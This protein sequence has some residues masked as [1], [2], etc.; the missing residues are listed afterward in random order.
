VKAVAARDG[1]IQ[2]TRGV[3]AVEAFP[4]EA[5]IECTAQ[6]LRDHGDTL[7][8][9]HPVRGFVPLRQ[10]LAEQI[11]VSVDQ[12]LV[13]NGSIQILDSLTHALFEPGDTILV[14]RPTYDRTVTTFRRAGLHVKGVSLDGDGM[15]LDELKA[16]I[17][18]HAPKALYVIP[19]FQNPSG[20]TTSLAKREAILE[21][22][23]RHRFLIV[24]DT[25][26]RLLRYEGED[27]TGFRELRAER[28]VEL[29]SF[30]KLISPGLRVGWMVASKAIVDRV[31]QV[32]VDTYISPSMLSHGAV[33]EF[34]RRGWMPDN[35][36][37]LKALYGPR[38][39]ATL[40]ALSSSL[41][42]VA[43]SHPE[44][45]FFLALTLPEGVSGEQMCQLAPQEGLELTRGEG[46]Y[47][48]GDGS[49]FLRLPFC[50]LRED[51]IKEAVSRLARVLER[52]EA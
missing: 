3:P 8:Q 44:G 48:D 22:A 40:A 49:R 50:A 25:P 28:V 52:A 45:G 19:D 21:L 36:E 39:R 38:L 4:T 41:P 46:F 29:S 47:A 26:Y 51:E 34:L 16:A 1:I 7:L 13:G 6:A 33:Y 23:H 31:A 14:E 12:I 5:I 9:Y 43:R 32:A 11:A 20:V 30:S 17:G 15:N 10:T 35:I 27:V 18:A 24:A 2:L 37:R 42:A